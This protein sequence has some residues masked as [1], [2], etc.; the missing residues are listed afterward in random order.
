MVTCGFLLGGSA[1]DIRGSVRGELGVPEDTGKH[2]K[3][4][5]NFL[6][7]AMLHLQWKT[8]IKQSCLYFKYCFIL[9]G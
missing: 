5:L 9:L 8:V 7:H 4:C 2:L 3:N 1:D 6:L